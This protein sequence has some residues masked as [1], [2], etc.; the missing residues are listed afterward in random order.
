MQSQP[1]LAEVEHEAAIL[2]AEVDHLQQPYTLA[3]I[4]AP[5]LARL[6]ET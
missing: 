4:R 6:F 3:R 1:A 5:I 2:G